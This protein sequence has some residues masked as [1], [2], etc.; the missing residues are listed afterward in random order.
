MFSLADVKMRLLSLDEL[1]EGKAQ[2]HEEE[3]FEGDAAVAK[4]EAL[5]PHTVQEA[6]GDS[7]LALLVSFN[8]D[9]T[10]QNVSAIYMLGQQPQL[11]VCTDWDGSGVASAVDLFEQLVPALGLE[12]K[13][14]SSN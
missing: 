4:Y 3:R 11:L 9:G 8:G 2:G 5:K 7:F 12:V 1:A 14:T 10:A 6:E 13:T